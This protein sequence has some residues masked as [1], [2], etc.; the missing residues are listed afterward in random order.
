M[1]QHFAEQLEQRVTKAKTTKQPK[2][3]SKAKTGRASVDRGKDKAAD[4][5][6]L[7]EIRVANA[8]KGIQL[9]G[10]LSDINNYEFTEE[11]V[12]IGFDRMLEELQAA[13]ARFRAAHHRRKR[14]P[15]SLL[16]APKAAGKKA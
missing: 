7:G 9:Y 10:N 6:R 2:V 5:I 14:A 1:P 4:F 3:A 13:R 16:S 12:E 8:C 11:Q 15:I